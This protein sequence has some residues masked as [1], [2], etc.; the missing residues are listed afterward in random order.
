MNS[1]DP[2]KLNGRYDDILR[3]LLRV[4]LGKPLRVIDLFAGCGGMSLGFHRAGYELL[5]GIELDP[6]A[7][8]THAINFFGPRDTERFA[9][10]CQ[11]H[12]ITK[13]TPQKF[14][15]DILREEDA[16]GLVDIIIGGP[17]CQSFARVGRAKLR[18]IMRHPHAFLQDERADLYLN[19]LEY[20]EFFHP[21]AVLLE[22][23]VDIMNYGRKNVAEEIA[24]SL[25]D[26]GY[27]TRYTILNA[28]HYGVPQMRQRF[29]LLAILETLE[30]VPSFPEPTHYMKLP[31]G[32]EGARQVALKSINL[33]NLHQVRYVEPV[34]P[35]ESLPNAVTA[36]E[37]IHDLPPITSHLDGTMKRGAKNFDQ[38]VGYRSDTT[39]SQYALQMRQW[40]GFES[41]GTILDHVTRYL[42]RDFALFSLMKPGDQYP[43]VYELANRLFHEELEKRRQQT[44]KPILEG[45]PEY[46]KLKSSIV[47][48]YDPGKFPNK[49]RKIEPDKPVRTLTA[50]IGKDTYSH[51][52]Y[53]SEQA[54]VIS[55]REAARLQSFPDGFIFTGPMNAAFRQIGNA[56]PPL[57]AYG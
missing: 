42:P 23:V 29:F 57:M 32:Y 45:T 24:A 55:V 17:P 56:V 26:L 54:R 5:G 31:P 40:P 48:P 4:K 44:G 49:W 13:L 51:I 34:E 3:K 9:I 35:S 22:N 14:M 8:E 21:L 39:P 53:D 38:A 36:E 33:F 50:H 46:E 25:E 6:K 52:H 47:P 12:D 7:A 10:H 28:S 2:R 19:F 11:P 37:A 43:E 16:A 15:T 20:V 18:E 41:T 1:L 27:S 30:T